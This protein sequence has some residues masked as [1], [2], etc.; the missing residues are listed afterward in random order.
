MAVTSDFGIRASVRN[1]KASDLTTT[2]DVLD[3]VRGVHLESGTTAG[4]ADKVF[5]DQ[6]TLAASASE[7]LDLAGVLTDVYGAAITFAKIKY[8]AVS[9]AAG[10]T[11]NVLVGAASA[12]QF[13]GLLNAAGV[14]TLRP[15]ATFAAMSGAADATGMAVTAGTGDLLKIAN[16]AGSTSVTYDIVIVGTSA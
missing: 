4:K 10:N 7:D 12:T 15:G 2:A 6:R 5:H 16:S 13:V 3:F 8:I 11:N 1:T 14:I 9:A